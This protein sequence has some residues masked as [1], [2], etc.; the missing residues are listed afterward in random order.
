MF[1]F[2]DLC[3]KSHRHQKPENQDA[4][5]ID[6]SCTGGAAGKRNLLCMAVFDGVSSN[7]G[8]VAATTS[9]DFFKGVFSEIKEHIIELSVATIESILTTAFHKAA[10]ELAQKRNFPATTASV[11]VIHENNMICLNAGDSPIFVY[12]GQTL[13][14]LFEC[15][16]KA[17]EALAAGL[18]TEEQALAD[19]NLNCHLTSCLGGYKLP[20]VHKTIYPLSG[21]CLL[22]IGSDGAF[23]GL[24]RAELASLC[25]NYPYNSLHHLQ[26]TI[27]ASSG[28]RTKDNQTLLLAKLNID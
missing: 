20:R 25:K 22:L 26:D 5:T 7:E 12:D 9:A 23:A 17:G 14:A 10:L 15:H 16:N 1:Y 8:L 24:T 4:Y 2:S 6:I 21:E 28:T 3:E 18:L 11:V 19:V 27:L 13:T